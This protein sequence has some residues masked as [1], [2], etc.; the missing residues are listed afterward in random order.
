MPGAAMSEGG[1]AESGK[2]PELLADSLR[3]LDRYEQKQ[4]VPAG[5]SARPTG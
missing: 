3:A 2:T 1:M 5:E 4:E